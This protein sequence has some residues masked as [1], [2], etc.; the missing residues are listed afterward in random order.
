MWWLESAG[1]LLLGSRCG[2][3]GRPGATL[4]ADCARRV[5]ELRPRPYRPH[6]SPPGLPLVVTGAAYEGIWPGLVSAYK[7]HQVWSLARPLG[8]LLWRALAELVIMTGVTGEVELVPMPSRGAAVRRRGLDTTAALA[9]RVGRCAHRAG[10]AVPVRHRLR[11]TR[12][13][14]DQAGLDVAGR[15]DN[16]AGALAARP[17]PG[18]RGTTVEAV[19]VDDLITTGASLA[20]AAR[21]L[22]AVG[23]PVLGAVT[24]AATSRRPRTAGRDVEG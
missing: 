6:P 1:D 5:A 7:E 12:A 21:A 24:L 9:R 8:S 10:W 2:G 11:F 16:L 22:H 17:A 4:C 18:G 13:V 19:I 15:R 23:R 3:C 20:E 14:A